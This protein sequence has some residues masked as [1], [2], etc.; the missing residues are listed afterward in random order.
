MTTEATPGALGSNDQLGPTV[1]AAVIDCWRVNYGLDKTPH[2]LHTF[3]KDG[4][5]PGAALALKAAVSEIE[6]LR[7][8]TFC[9]C[10]DQFSAH[11]PGTCGACVAGMTCAPG[12]NPGA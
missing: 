6:R 12:W 9:G 10:G 1:D 8:L 7:L 2:D 11:D 4:S 3:W 5:P